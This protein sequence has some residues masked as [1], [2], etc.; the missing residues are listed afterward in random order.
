MF[1]KF[2]LLILLTLTVAFNQE[3]NIIPAQKNAILT[4]SL[5]Q[6]FTEETLDNYL[7]RNYGVTIHGLKKAQ[8]IQIINRF[9]STNP[10]KPSVDDNIKTEIIIPE[11]ILADILE[12]GMSKR[13]YLVDDNVIEGKILSIEA[14]KCEIET[15]DGKLFIPVNEILEETVDITKKD[16][17]RFSFVEPS[18]PSGVEVLWLALRDF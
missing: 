1:K 10:P 9:Q 17:T 16:E 11:P 18:T 12:V 7:I 6:G 14:G 4:L 3:E 5:A 2:L 8:A 13:F 15:V